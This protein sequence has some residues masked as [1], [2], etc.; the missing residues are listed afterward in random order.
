MAVSEFYPATT[1][2]RAE[3]LSRLKTE[4]GRVQRLSRG[5]WRN[6]GSAF[7]V[8]NHRVKVAHLCGL[9]LNERTFPAGVLTLAHLRRV[10][11]SYNNL[12][13]LPGELARLEA[14]QEIWLDANPLEELP[15]SLHRL[16]HLRLLSLRELPRL[17]NVP[18]EYAELRPTLVD[19]G[20]LE[21]CPVINEKLLEALRERGMDGFF[22]VLEIKHLRRQQQ[23]K[24]MKVLSEGL[25]PFEDPS[26]L[27]ACAQRLTRK[28]KIINSATPEAAKLAMSRLIKH[29]ER[30]FPAVFSELDE[31]AVLE[32]LKRFDEELQ[33]REEATALELKVKAAMPD[34]P[35][36]VAHRLALEFRSTLS[37]AKIGSIVRDWRELFPLSKMSTSEMLGK[38]MFGVDS[39][40]ER[41]AELHRLREL[42]LIRSSLGCRAVSTAQF[43]AAFMRAYRPAAEEIVNPLIDY[44]VSSTRSEERKRLVAENALKERLPATVEDSLRLMKEGLPLVVTDEPSPGSPD[45]NGVEVR[46]AAAAVGDV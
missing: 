8:R 1:V 17:R 23:H 40:L 14:L 4:E 20:G 43:R 38:G 27:Q 24:L 26:A 35:G 37:A 6:A 15:V 36:D 12:K 44:F 42:E 16:K 41:Q 19:V 34:L 7:R 9:R 18:R 39:I 32:R 21:D 29:G 10:D 5:A 28:I 33:S 45:G 31:A 11:L 13:R 3:L 46:A 25:Y 22:T 30:I 2:T